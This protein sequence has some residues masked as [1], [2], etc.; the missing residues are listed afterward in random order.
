[1]V[2]TP[3]LVANCY[4][5]FLHRNFTNTES[6]NDHV[7]EGEDEENDRDCEKKHARDRSRESW[8]RISKHYNFSIQ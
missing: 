6:N 4:I 3:L 1:M 7:D 8:V 2:V 5:N